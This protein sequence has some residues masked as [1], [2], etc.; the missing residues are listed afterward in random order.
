M[1]NTKLISNF[2]EIIIAAILLYVL[3]IIIKVVL[4]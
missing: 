4:V 2:K 1:K 3:W